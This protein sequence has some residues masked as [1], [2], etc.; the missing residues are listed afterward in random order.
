MSPESLMRDLEAFLAEA[1]SAV[2]FEDG[3]PIFDLS[4]ARYSVSADH[5]KCLLHLWSPE[6]NTIRRVLEAE[7]KDGALVLSVQRFGQAKP[8]KFE[9][10]RNGDRRSALARSVGRRQYCKLLQK[11]L[12][13]QFPAW[14]STPLTS[15]MDLER[16]FSPVYARGLV[17][18][19]QSAFAVLGVNA[20]ELQAS[21]DGALTFALLWLEHCRVKE[22]A[23]MVVEG[24]K[25]FLPPGTSAVARER[26]AC[27]DHTRAKFELYE[28]NEAEQSIQQLDCHDRGNIATHL[29]KCLNPAAA[30]ERLKA[31]ID[32]VLS[33]VQY[34]SKV[35]L[36]PISSGE[37]AFRLH[38]L[39]FARARS[40]PGKEKTS[41]YEI[42]FGAGP[43]ETVLDADTENFFR[44]LVG[45]LLDS[46]LANG[47]HNHAL[48]RMQPER[49]L[50]SLIVKNVC[51]IDSSF[52]PAYVYSQVPAFSA[53]DRAMIDV[54][55]STREGRLAV[56]ELKADEDIHLPLQGLDYWARVEWHHLRGEFAANGYFAGKDLSPAAPLLLMIAP[57]LRIHP[58]TDTL[59]RYFSPDID[60]TLLG[61]DERWREGVRVVFRKRA[62]SSAQ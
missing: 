42:T 57:A 18:R 13:R 4:V 22:A 46:R 43:Y 59:L 47:D 27:L 2:V 32:R 44:Q 33:F 28:F 26:L 7:H 34:P 24:L 38:G 55:T 53:G 12:A 23:R 39:E 54:L 6:R 56:L 15:A 20:Q 50:E 16:S 52:D 9:I 37:M 30:K 1:R 48:W 10:L 60:C 61:V 29:V 51:A 17:R 21:V 41:G 11:A 31:A 45:R 25:L 35:Q 40:L 49:W 58:A 36:V 8:S 19:G 5:G 62:P 3:E 14:S